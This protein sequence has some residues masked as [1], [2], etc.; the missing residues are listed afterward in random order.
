MSYLL[1]QKYGDHDGHAF[2]ISAQIRVIA[3]ITL[4]L[5]VKVTVLVSLEGLI[6]CP[7]DVAGELH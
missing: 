2:W 1:L 6:R 5:N 3:E 7:Q 4:F